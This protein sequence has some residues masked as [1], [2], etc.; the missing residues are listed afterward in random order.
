MGEAHTRCFTFTFTEHGDDSWTSRSRSRSSTLGKNGPGESPKGQGHGKKKGEKNILESCLEDAA[1]TITKQGRVAEKKN[2][3]VP[4]Y[5]FRG[6][7]SGA[8]SLPHASPSGRIN[9]RHSRVVLGSWARTRSLGWDGMG[10]EGGSTRKESA[11]RDHQLPLACG[12]APAKQ[13]T[14]VAGRFILSESIGVP[15]VYEFQHTCFTNSMCVFMNF[16][17]CGTLQHSC[18]L[19]FVRN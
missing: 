4:R 1:T 9:R 17:M 5:F 6:W 18:I 12:L 15:V 10:W 11:S 8:P 7:E 3:P 13:K 14:A 16:G 19:L 2:Q